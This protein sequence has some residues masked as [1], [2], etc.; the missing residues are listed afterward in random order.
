MASKLSSVIE[1]KQ[2]KERELLEEIFSLAEEMETADKQ[3]MYGKLALTTRKKILATLFY[4]PSTRTRLSFESAMIRLGGEVI[5]TEDAPTFSSVTKGESLVDTIRV[6]G[7]YADVI[8]LRHHEE[9]SSKIAT[10]VSPVPIINAGDGTGQHP[11]QALLDIYTI[12][13]ELGRIDDLE[14]GLA[15]DLL[16]G[17]TVHSLTYLLA[18]QKGIKLYFVSPEEIRL[19]RDI[20][21]YLEEE[22]GGKEDKVSFEETTDLKEIISKVD[23]LYVTRIQKERFRNIEDYNR[24][25]GSYVID[26][27]MVSLMKK[28]SRIL[29]PLPR[30]DEIAIE[31]DNDPRAA[32]FRQVHN[33]L[34]LRMALL[35]MIL[36]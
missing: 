24:L 13:K 31:V 18:Q 3:G 2:F 17:R 34:Y 22:K 7:S 9:G 35:K 1:V 27:E 14:V 21:H 19:P 25:R 36:D 12:R 5:S 10:E 15:G 16:Y 29:H 20:I 6:I 23:V 33:G 26:K 4:E 30:V 11:T 28:T 8:V 32:Y